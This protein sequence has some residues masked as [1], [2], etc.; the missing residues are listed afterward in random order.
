MN[1][2]WCWMYKASHNV[3]PIWINLQG[4]FH[5][6]VLL[7]LA[8]WN[9]PVIDVSPFLLVATLIIDMQCTESYPRCNVVLGLKKVL[10][11][12]TTGY[13]I[14]WHYPHDSLSKE[15]AAAAR[16]NNS[17]QQYWGAE[18]NCIILKALHTF[19]A[20]SNRERPINLPIFSLSWG[21]FVKNTRNCSYVKA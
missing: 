21:Y 13:L 20:D 19:K 12:C 16:I 5:M 18:D 14:G 4:P 8:L 17:A 2:Q 15:E 7:F 11:P 6:A 3:L 9:F 10:H 1:A